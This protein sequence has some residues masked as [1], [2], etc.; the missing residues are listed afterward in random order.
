MIVYGEADQPA[1]PSALLNETAR[2]WRT[3]SQRLRP[4]HDELRGELIALGEIEAAIG[5]ALCPEA[6]C[7]DSRLRELRGVSIALGGLFWRSWRDLPAVAGDRKLGTLAATLDALAHRA[8]PAE[9]RLRPAEGYAHYALFPEGYG[10]AAAAL[11][12]ERAAD[13]AL[14]VGIR[15]IGTSLSAA[16]AGALAQ[17]GIAVESWC[18]RPRGHPFSRALA[19]DAGLRGAWAAAASAGALAVVVDEGPGLSGSSFLSVRQELRRAGFADARI[20]LMPSWDAPPPPMAGEA[21]AHAWLQALK[22]PAV[23]D[24][25]RRLL[26]GAADLQDLSAGRWRKHLLA[27]RRWPAVQRQHERLKYLVTQKDAPPRL[28]RFAG[29]GSYGAPRLARARAL[30]EAGFAPP[31]HGLRDGFLVQDFAP[32]RPLRRKDLDRRLADRVIAYIVFRARSF[33]TG[34]STRIAQVSEMIRINLGEGLDAQTHDAVERV[35]AAADALSDLPT[36]SVDSRMMPHEWLDAG[37]GLV[38]ADAVDHAD[39]HFFPRDQDIAWDLAGFSAEFSLSP[40]R[41]GELAERLAAEIGDRQLPRRM[42]FY[43]LAYRSFHLGYAELAI[44]ALGADDPD[45][46]RFRLRSAQIIEDLRTR[47]AAAMPSKSPAPVFGRTFMDRS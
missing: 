15:S 13:S 19:L 25:A 7:I 14:V 38:K 43:G 1:D 11:A 31:E 29:L 8:W 17:C 41:E 34:R 6:D 10:E 36:V 42:P 46:K 16:V 26:A 37:S 21:G 3:L 12:A 45:A 40:E 4:P 5:D 24:P 18:V 22:R 44:S 30:A 27:G 20:V 35:L 39:D 32:G 33:Q 2:R 9:V 23:F 47:L 28:W